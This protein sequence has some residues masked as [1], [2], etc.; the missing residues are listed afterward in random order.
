[1]KSGKSRLYTALLSA[2]AV[3]PVVV[4]A[5]AIAS[6]AALAGLHTAEAPRVTQAVDDSA[7]TLVQKSHLVLLDGKA[8]IDRVPD[9]LPMNHMQLVLKRSAL[10]QSALEGLLAAQHDPHSPTFHRWVNPE[11]FGTT[12]GVAD[13][14]IAAATS[15]L[16]AHGFTV[17][18]VYPN[19]MQIDFSGTAGL[20]K[21]TF[22]TQENHYTINNEVHIANGSDIRLPI[23]LKDVVFG[24]A[25]LTDVRPG[26]N[27]QSVTGE[28]DP[29]TN[30]FRTEASKTGVHSQAIPDGTG[31]RFFVPYDMHK[32]YGTDQLLANGVT[33]KGVTIAVV[34][35]HSMVASDWTNFVAQF[36]LGT[37][38]GTFAIIQPQAGFGLGRLNCADPTQGGVRVQDDGETL[39][40]AEWATA[41]APGAHVEV[42]SCADFGSTNFFGGVVTAATNLINGKVRPDIISGSYGF[43]E[44][45]VDSASKSAIDQMWAQADA[46]GISV[47]VSSGDSGSAP[48]FNGSFIRGTPAIDASAFGTSPHDTVVGGTDTADVLDGTTSQ[49]FSTTETADYGTA[50]SYVP[51]IPWNESCGNPV[52]AT[53]MHYPTAIAFCRASLISD[54]DG[55]S[56][57]SESGSGGPSS[58]D[59][60]PAWQSL[61]RG[62]AADGWRDVPDV[63][64]FAGAYG[65][66]SWAIVCTASLPCTPGFS[67]QVTAFSGTSL[68]SPMFAGIQALIDQD[69]ASKGLTMDQG[70]AAPILY[71]LAAKEYGSPTSGT[72]K[73][74][75]AC[76]SDNGTNGTSGC[77]FHNIRRGGMS[78]QC[79]QQL[80]GLVTPDCFFYGNIQDIFGQDGP[81][82]VGLTSTSATHYSPAFPAQPGWSFATGL[83]SVNAQN[84]DA[85]WTSYVEAH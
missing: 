2:L 37:Y 82:Q 27:N 77:V 39:L 65:G 26:P 64:L 9:S 44:H 43:G 58:I 72:P 33:G 17:N 47:F 6:P 42:A 71:A 8:P 23:A 78:T 5:P 3:L 38:G 51:E 30:K 12:F 68:S 15:W 1:M 60:K 83:G 63:S 31:V 7:S 56:L 13:S 16:V 28:F 75:V 34:E 20:V 62:S 85:A 24:V 73:S 69:L 84:L 74:L 54:P 48:S 41:M 76:N 32:M 49:Y 70:N 40:D 29:A 18:G 46:E 57:T 66:H 59:A 14:D 10:R 22:H 53:S 36:S 81:V 80:P 4:V 19:K 55:F 21:S 61:V 67:T 50:L 25:G 79:V 45:M 52:A 35:D 11:E